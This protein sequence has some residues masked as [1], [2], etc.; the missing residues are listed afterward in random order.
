MISD[1]R[2]VDIGSRHDAV[3]TDRHVDDE[4]RAILVLVE[5]GQIGR[6][7]RRQHR[8]DPRRC[9]HRGRVRARV[10]VER[11]PLD[12]ERVNVGDGDQEPGAARGDADLELI[13]IPRVVVVDR[14]PGQ[15]AEVAQ[16]GFVRCREVRELG[17][18]LRRP[19]RLEPVLHHRPPRDPLEY[20]AVIL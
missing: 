1:H 13:E 7:L 20:G 3:R 8:E 18:R 10:A 9:V 19:V 6:E 15:V 16:A 11:G 12:H 2:P 5:R 17:V 4:G 14:R